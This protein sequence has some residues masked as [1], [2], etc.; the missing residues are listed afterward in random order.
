MFVFN[1]KP[2]RCTQLASILVAFSSSYSL[3]S[4]IYL[5]EAVRLLIHQAL[6]CGAQVIGISGAGVT[7]AFEQE[8]LADAIDFVLEH[9]K[10][11]RTPES[12]PKVNWKIGISSGELVPVYSDSGF[13]NFAVGLGAF[14]A[15]IFAYQAH[16]HEIVFDALVFESVQDR[17][18]EYE[19]RIVYVDSNPIETIVLSPL[20][21]LEEL[22]IESVTSQE[23]EP[24]IPLHNLVNVFQEFLEIP[25]NKDINAPQ[26]IIQK[27][28]S[29]GESSSVLERFRA[30]MLASQGSLSDAFASAYNAISKSHSP[31]ERIRNLLSLAIVLVTTSHFNEALHVAFEALAL[32]KEHST[33]ELGV[34]AC[35]QIIDTIL[36][37]QKR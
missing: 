28:E 15:E 27:L 2:I 10:P 22:E 33:S 11:K 12:V 34:E 31:R 16:N 24:T 37:H 4:A 3:P 21:Q 25:H 5:A 35:Q 13:A 6:A 19:S 30:L 7:F 29:M 17:F 18:H 32:E 8:D 1:D 20:S 26:S 14:Y 36:K 23:V 9:M